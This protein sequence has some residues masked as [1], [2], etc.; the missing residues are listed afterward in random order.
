MLIA[1]EDVLDI[2]SAVAKKYL[3]EGAVQ[4]LAT[5]VGSN[6]LL[7]LPATMVSFFLYLWA[8]HLGP[9]VRQDELQAQDARNL[10]R[11]IS[12]RWV[13]LIGGFICAFIVFAVDNVPE[14]MPQPLHD[15]KLWIEL[16]YFSLFSEIPSQ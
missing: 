3:Y 2:G 15:F 5:T 14:Y 16:N 4:D 6:I 7:F 13:T 8:Q 12:L 9:R 11:L 10:Q 1:A